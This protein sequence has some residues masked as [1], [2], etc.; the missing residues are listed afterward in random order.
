MTAYL[1]GEYLPLGNCCIPANDRGFILGDAVYEVIAVYDNVP[2][3]TEK[4]LVR[5]EHSLGS[6]GIPHPHSRDEWLAIFQR[7]I[8]SEK[9]R[10]F[11][12]YLQVT[13]GAAPRDIAVPDKIK[14]LVFAMTMPHAA[15]AP[16]TAIRAVTREDFRWQRCDVKTTSLMA[17]VMLRHNALDAGCNDAIMVREG[18]VTEATAANVFTVHG[19]ELCTPPKGIYILSGVT[20]DVIIEIAAARG[21]RVRE[22]W[23]DADHLLHADEV[24]LT[25]STREITP[26]AE[27]DGRVIGDGASYPLQRQFSEWLAERA[28]AQPGR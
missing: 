18:K 15:P 17:S 7:L 23:F 22:E 13:R 10:D 28:K 12:L 27:V 21:V 25:S 5:L 20:R 24:W 14:P 6:S 2:F 9:A 11:G 4:H 19:G 16:L 3:E 26:V 1:N 8:Q